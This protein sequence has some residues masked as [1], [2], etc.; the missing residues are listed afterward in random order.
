[1]AIKGT[2]HKP[3]NEHTHGGNTLLPSDQKGGSDMLCVADNNST[4]TEKNICNTKKKKKLRKDE[5]ITIATAGKMRQEKNK[6]RMTK[7]RG[8]ETKERAG[9]G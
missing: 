2:G 5:N 7:I 9:Q 3:H 1:M 6:E 8:N 4:D